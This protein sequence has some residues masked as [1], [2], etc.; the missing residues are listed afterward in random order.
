MASLMLFSI[1]YQQSSPIYCSLGPVAVSE[2]DTAVSFVFSE[3]VWPRGIEEGDRDTQRDRE[4]VREIEREVRM[5]ERQLP[6]P[7][8]KPHPPSLGPEDDHLPAEDQ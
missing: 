2:G 6:L 1:R 8:V 7:Q 5:T 3:M 4:T